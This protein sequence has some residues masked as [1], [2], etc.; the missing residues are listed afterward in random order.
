VTRADEV[1]FGRARAGEADLDFLQ[2]NLH[3]Q[4]E[5]AVLLLRAHRIDQALVAVAQVGGEPA[6][7][8]SI[9]FDGQVRSGMLICG[10][11]RYLTEGSFSMGMISL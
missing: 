7:A 3:Q 4:V 2:A 5:E 11:G 10:K 9:T 6:G 8:L 1:I